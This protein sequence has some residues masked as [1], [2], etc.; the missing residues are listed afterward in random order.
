MNTEM[1][2][3]SLV[4][5]EAF[6]FER[7]HRF[8]HERVQQIMTHELRLHEDSTDDYLL[9][10][11]LP[12]R[13]FSNAAVPDSRRIDSAMLKAVG[14]RIPPLGGRGGHGRFNVDGFLNQ[15]GHE[16]VS[17]Y[18]LLFRDGRAESL[19]PSIRF[20]MDRTGEGNGPYAVRDSCIE[21]GVLQTTKE[22]L[23]SMEQLDMTAPV[24]LFSCVVGC[25]G[26]HIC[27]H[28]GFR[29]L[30]RNK[31]DRSPCFLSP[32]KIEQP[33]AEIEAIIRPW[34][35]LFWQAFGLEH[36]FNFDESGNWRE[37]RR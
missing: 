19:M 6:Q 36:S 25:K 1:L 2:G 29:D 16:A 24:W 15:D 32:L 35:D 4:R 34:C 10:H 22:Y 23:A 30:S 28:W 13:A 17:A 5:R 8:H 37:R 27:T 14:G 18:T 31:M 20:S 3:E 26:V 33:F 11:L 21:Q 9:L 7:M 12:E